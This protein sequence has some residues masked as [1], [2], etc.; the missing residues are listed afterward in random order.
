MNEVLKQIA[1]EAQI[2]MV[3]EPRLQQ[4]AELIIQRCLDHVECEIVDAQE[5]KKYWTVDTLEAIVNGIR[6]EFDMEL[7]NDNPRR[8]N[9][10]SRTN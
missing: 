10:S 5:Q 7:H 6:E 1:E 9:K 4:Y 3:S 8:E 2:A